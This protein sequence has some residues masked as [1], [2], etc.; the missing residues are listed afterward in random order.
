MHL[1]WQHAMRGGKQVLRAMLALALAT[2][3]AALRQPASSISMATAPPKRNVVVVGAGWAGLSTAWS[4]SRDESV[5]VTVVDAAPRP[6]GVV[7]DGFKTKLGKNAEAGQHGFWDE[8]HNI[9]RL[10]YE[11]LGLT[12]AA[13]PLTGYAEQGQYSPNGLE[14]VWPVYRDR[15]NLP[16]GLGQALFTR[17]DNLSPFELATAAPLVAAF[18]EFDGSPDA[19][20]RFDTLSFRDLCTKLG[21]SR[22]LYDEAFE[23]MILTG[24]FA[25]GEQ[26]SAAAA[27]GMAYFF[28]LK[29]QKSFDVRWCKGNVGDRIFAPWCDELRNR[30]AD[31]KFGTKVT[32]LEV[33]GGGVRAVALDDGSTLACDDVVF[34]VGMRA[35]KGLS[36]APSLANLPEFR[37]FG[38]LRGTDVL[39][40][41]LYLD[42][43]VDTPYSANACWGFDEKVGMTWFDLRK[44]HGI[45]EMVVE[46]DFYH[47]GSL[48]GLDDDAI[49]DRAKSY[50]D[51]MVPAFAGAAVVDAA[52]VKL[53]EAV[54]WFYPGS[55]ASCPTTTSASLKNAYF[56]GDVVRD[57]GHGSWSQEKAFVS[58]AVA[59]NAIL[60][61]DAL[62]GVAPLR[63]DEAHV[64]FGRAASRTLRGALAFGGDGPSLASVPW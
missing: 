43:V 63:D 17:F 41:R 5:R 45:D 13:D 27:L 31:L 40:T 22:K 46:V 24:L 21:V 48:M 10:L 54:N 6:G 18:S 44:M 3:V 55:Y 8:Y 49:V 25:P 64:A 26:C 12:G 60:G 33:S 9:Y 51:T 7:R 58:G 14:A 38:N 19:W 28:V 15:P 32:G 37:K 39:A 59:A 42:S 29:G 61:R 56:A 36:K 23:P 2:H 11:D 47:S 20:R 62:D 34:A 4:L 53:P 35:L 30:G 52:V 16:T 1:M 50:L 57:L